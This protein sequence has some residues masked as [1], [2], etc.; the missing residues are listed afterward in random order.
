MK[1]IMAEKCRRCQSSNLMYPVELI[2]DLQAPIPVQLKFIP[3]K[4]PGSLFNLQLTD[5]VT[6]YA[7]VCGNC[8]LTE[9]YVDNP[10][11]IWLKWQ[12]GFK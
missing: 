7:S 9:L 1:D 5:R 12:S 2:G 8:G 6:V 10:D 3:P 4:R 11:E